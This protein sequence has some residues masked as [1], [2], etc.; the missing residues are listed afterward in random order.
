MILS[1]NSSR[2]AKNVFCLLLSS[3]FSSISLS[4]L[5]FVSFWTV[6]EFSIVF[7]ISS[8]SCSLISISSLDVPIISLISV[9][10]SVKRCFSASIRSIFCCSKLA[11]RATF[12]SSTS[13]AASSSLSLLSSL[14]LSSRSLFNLPTASSHACSS[15]LDCCIRSRIFFLSCSLFPIC[16]SSSIDS[17]FSE[18]VSA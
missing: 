10:S 16:F 2:L 14:L 3:S 13:A 12:S 18:S 7:L 15:S 5:S 9:S 11:S 8:I 4:S 1:F 6:Y 17:F